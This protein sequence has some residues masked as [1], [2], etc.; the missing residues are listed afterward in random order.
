MDNLNSEAII[1]GNAKFQIDVPYRVIE[2]GEKSIN[3]PLIIYLH[4]LV[5]I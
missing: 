5:K 4:G 3:K 1:T 2:T